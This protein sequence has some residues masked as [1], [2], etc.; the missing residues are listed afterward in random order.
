MS[1]GQYPVELVSSNVRLRLTRDYVLDL[2]TAELSPPLT[3]EEQTYGQAV[4]QVA[5]ANAFDVTVCDAGNGYASI[6]TGSYGRNPYPNSTRLETSLLRF[7]SGRERD[8]SPIA[9]NLQPN[10]STTTNTYRTA[11]VPANMTVDEILASGRNYSFPVC[12]AYDGDAY[13][14]CDGCEPVTYT[15]TDITYG[16]TDAGQLCGGSG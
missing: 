13:V 4:P 3:E 12:R 1:D 5:M 14:V 16:C 9:S 2:V 6:C 7:S 8:T 10:A 11:T 15:A